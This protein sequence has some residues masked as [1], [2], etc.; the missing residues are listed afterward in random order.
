MSLGLNKTKRRIASVKSTQKITKAMGMV[1][2]VKLKRFKDAVAATASYNAGLRRIMAEL[3]LHDE[4]TRTHYAEE[5][6]SVEGTL[7]IVVTSNLGLCGAYNNNLYKFIESVVDPSK[8]FLL[9]VGEKGRAHYAHD[10]RFKDHLVLDPLFDSSLDPKKVDAN[11]RRIKDD[12]NQKKYRKIALIYTEYINSISFQPRELTL[13]PVV[14]E[15]QPREDESYCPPLF[16]PSA[17]AQI[18]DLLPYY[19]G[20]ELFHKIAQA[21]LCEQASRRN[22]MD[23]ANDNAD[24]LLAK[25]TI[26]YNKA[27]QTAI[28]QE[29]VEV[30]SGSANA[31]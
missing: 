8:D 11:C 10:P 3:F 1:A 12:F 24:E 19:L 23:A 6:T 30:V 25:L 18:H 2:T 7:Y 15:P 13:L 16:E 20:S 9:P 21:D 28:T 4:E 22:A 14:L 31:N 29:I 5:N 17:R 26:E 27:R